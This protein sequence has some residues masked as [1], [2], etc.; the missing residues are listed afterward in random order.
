MAGMVPDLALGWRHPTP[1]AMEAYEQ[2]E[3]PGLEAPPPETEAL[4]RAEAVVA[5]NRAA[6]MELLYH[7]DGRDKPGHPRY[8]T[9]T[10][11]WEQH[12]LAVGRAII[13]PLLTLRPCPL[14]DTDASSV[15]IEVIHG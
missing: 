8:K 11:L 13:D 2:L 5:E 7:Q 14:V 12:C 6:L 4:P 10:G 9:F 3:I 1:D 15:S